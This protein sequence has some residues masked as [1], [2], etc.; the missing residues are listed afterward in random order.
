V[1]DQQAHQERITE[2]GREVHSYSATETELCVGPMYEE[3]IL[4]IVKVPLQL[5][6]VVGDANRTTVF[7]E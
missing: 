3:R 5:L 4:R 7:E 1:Q 6:E 2:L